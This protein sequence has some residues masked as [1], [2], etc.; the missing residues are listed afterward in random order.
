MQKIS[1]EFLRGWRASICD[2]LGNSSMA[3]YR[4]NHQIERVTPHGILGFCCGRKRVVAIQAS[5]RS[6]ARRGARVAG[7]LACVCP[8]TVMAGREQI[9]CLNPDRSVSGL[10]ICGPARPGAATHLWNRFHAN[11]LKIA[12]RRLNGAS[13]RVADEEDLVA[14]AFESFFQRM[15]DGQFP[16]SARAGGIVGAA[17]HHYRSQGGQLRA[18]HMSAKRGGGR[19]WGSRRSSAPEEPGSRRPAGARRWWRAVARSTG[20]GVRNSWS[21]WMTICGGSSA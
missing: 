17:G 16:G 21:G 15:Q 13:R 3:Y 11:L 2:S 20:H 12:R 9:A 4:S 18:R 14:I 1:P 6:A 10:R 5:T 19:C 8:G 7:R